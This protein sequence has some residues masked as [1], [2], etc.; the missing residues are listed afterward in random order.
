[1]GEACQRLSARLRVEIFGTSH[2]F[3]RSFAEVGPLV[4]MGERVL[5]EIEWCRSLCSVRSVG[6]PREDTG[7]AA[8]GRPTMGAHERA[9]RIGD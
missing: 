4:E 2:T 5:H 6:R 1:M 8:M 7:V 9:S 3:D